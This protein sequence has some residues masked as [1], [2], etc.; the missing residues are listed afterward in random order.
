MRIARLFLALLMTVGVQAFAT[1]G[2]LESPPSLYLVQALS[3]PLIAF[4]RELIRPSSEPLIDR[5]EKQLVLESREKSIFPKVICSI[6]PGIVMLPLGLAQ[7]PQCFCK[8][9]DNQYMGSKSFHY[10]WAPWGRAIR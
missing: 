9:I 10:I 5:R 6:L 2:P 7:L 8:S 4:H 3:E 1:R